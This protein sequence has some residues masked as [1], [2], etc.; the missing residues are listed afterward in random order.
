MDVT[1]EG[2]VAAVVAPPHRLFLESHFSRR[3]SKLDAVVEPTTQET[4]AVPSPLLLAAT[5][6]GAAGGGGG[7]SGVVALTELEYADAPALL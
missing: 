5:L 2:T 7:T 3:T 4:T 6:L 1:L